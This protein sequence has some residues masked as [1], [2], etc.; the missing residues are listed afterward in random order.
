[1]QIDHNSMVLESAPVGL[2]DMV[3][4]SIEMMAADASRKGLDVAYAIDPPL[5]ARR[6]MGDSIRIR[7]VGAAPLRPRPRAPACACLESPRRAQSLVVHPLP[8]HEGSAPAGWARGGHGR[9]AA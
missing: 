1:M 7:Q 2:R 3:E 5:L 8:A 6:L 4:A 9:W